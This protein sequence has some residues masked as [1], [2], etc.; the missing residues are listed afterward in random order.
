MKKTSVQ[1]SHASVPLKAENF[2]SN[3][4]FSKPPKMKG[5]TAKF[6]N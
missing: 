6:K 2:K 3:S 5:V 1:K 4:L